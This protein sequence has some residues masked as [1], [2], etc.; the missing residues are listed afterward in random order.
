MHET[1]V[2]SGTCAMCAGVSRRS[3]P[4]SQLVKRVVCLHY[5][6]GSVLWLLQT[7][8]VL[9]VVMKATRMMRA[10]CTA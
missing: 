8:S 3:P 10:C 6:Y 2:R 4:L 5:C 9:K 1:I 7:A